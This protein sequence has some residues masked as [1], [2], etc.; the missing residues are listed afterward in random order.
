MT[1]KKE[2]LMWY[3]YKQ[4]RLVDEAEYISES[5]S[6]DALRMMAEGIALQEGLQKE[7]II[8]NYGG[9]KNIVHELP[10]G[11][12]SKFTIQEWKWQ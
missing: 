1:L 5:D 12:Q 6:F 7:D 8:W 11:Q 9:D 10:I 3:L 4:N 2:A